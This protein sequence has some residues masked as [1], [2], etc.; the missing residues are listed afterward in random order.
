MWVPAPEEIIRA[1]IRY[2]DDDLGS[3][4]TINE[5]LL[6][7][8]LQAREAL[9]E[10]GYAPHEWYLEGEDEKSVRREWGKEAEDLLEGN[11]NL[12]L[13]TAAIALI[14]IDDITWHLDSG[15]ATDAALS[16][17]KIIACS[18]LPSDSK[19][20]GLIQKMTPYARQGK[21]MRGGNA[22]KRDALGKLMEVTFRSLYEQTNK[23]PTWRMVLDSLKNFDS[24]NELKQT[25]QEISKDDEAIYWSDARGKGK[26]TPFKKFQDRLTDIRKKLK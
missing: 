23:M 5:I 14:G 6:R 16:M 10:A 1:I 20:S 18:L 21:K 3:D 13:E 24:D 11:E 19:Q 9:K 8:E 25:I 15:R 22:G 2:E 4:Y 26:L 12:E 7:L 17:M